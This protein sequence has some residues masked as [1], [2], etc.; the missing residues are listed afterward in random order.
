MNL[1]ELIV[2]AVEAAGFLFA[3]LGAMG[4]VRRQKRTAAKVDEIHAAVTTSE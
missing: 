1:A 3:G 2:N 4:I